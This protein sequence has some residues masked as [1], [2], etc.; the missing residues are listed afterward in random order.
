MIIIFEQIHAC[1]FEDMQSVPV[2]F[3]LPHFRC[4]TILMTP[5]R[6]DF[7][8]VDSTCKYLP[9]PR[10]PMKHFRTLILFEQNRFKML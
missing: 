9:V 6:K 7:E 5:I 2:C 4:S 3:A 1:T 8:H 10:Y